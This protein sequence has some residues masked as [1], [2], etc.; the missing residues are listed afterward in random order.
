MRHK[1]SEDDIVI[2]SFMCKETSK[3]RK[4]RV[5]VLGICFPT[6]WDT[7][8]RYGIELID[9]MQESI[10]NKGM[11]EIIQKYKIVKA[12]DESTLTLVS[13]PSKEEKSVADILQEIDEPSIAPSG[14]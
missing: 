3:H 11:T 2:H 12:V 9:R 7:E 1:Y 8:P 13:S 6:D 5:K 10:G 4:D 14:V